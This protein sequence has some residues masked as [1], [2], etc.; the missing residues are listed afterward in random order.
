MGF[1]A[2]LATFTSMFEQGAGAG[3]WLHW[4]LSSAA[5]ALVI[6]LFVISTVTAAIG[7]VLS[8]WFWRAWIGRKHRARRHRWNLLPLLDDS[9][10]EPDA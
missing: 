10:E 1:H 5:P 2:D 3:E 8:V 4:L 9:D 6:G 7:Y